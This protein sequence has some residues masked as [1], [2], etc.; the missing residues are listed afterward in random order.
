M[1]CPMVWTELK[2]EMVTAVE[3]IQQQ[4]TNFGFLDF[5]EPDFK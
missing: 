1:G 5:K 3:A 4:K 2:H